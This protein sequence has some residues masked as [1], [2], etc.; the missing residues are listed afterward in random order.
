M[1][2]LRVAVIGLAAVLV[3]LSAFSAAGAQEANGAPDVSGEATLSGPSISL[4]ATR[5]APGDVLQV[6]FAG[7][8]ANNAELSIC[9]NQAMRG[10][11]D[12]NTLQ[13]T[14]VRLRHSTTGE[15]PLQAMVVVNPPADCPCV[16]KASASDTGEVT[17]AAIDL[18]GHPISE[19][20]SPNLG[21]PVVNV[22]LTVADAPGGFVTRLKESL[23]GETAKLATVTVTNRTTQPVSGV[24]VHGRAS[25]R[26]T[27]AEFDLLPGVIGPGQT[28]T[29]TTEVALPA[30]AMGEYEWEV[31]ASGAGPVMTADE[32]VRQTPWF[33]IVLL[34]VFAGVLSSLV[35]RALQRRSA[36][37]RAHRAMRAV[38]LDEATE[39]SA[40]EG[41][42]EDGHDGHDGLRIDREPVGAGA[43]G[44][45]P[46]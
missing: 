38:G 22:G 39:L 10:A 36:E 17:Y 7:W 15:T 46:S 42:H 30:P 43:G 29:E 35:V 6:T 28:W 14:G 11:A 23:G 27:V 12:C 37:A 2:R 45:R 16:V 31:T 13:A 41:R 34:V 9:G 5:V 26:G 25:R 8:A 19:V 21:Q 18:I 33:F 24:T 1:R 40:M 3:G 32:T 44:G 20:V 4:N